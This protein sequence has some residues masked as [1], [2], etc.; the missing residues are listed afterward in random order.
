MLQLP[1]LWS[2]LWL[3]ALTL[4]AALSD[5]RTGLIPNWLT[6]PT[7][8]AAPLVHALLAGPGALAASLAAALLCALVPLALFGLHAIG[9]GDVKLFAAI[10]AIG[11]V[12]LGLQAQLLSYALCALG[13][14]CVLA[15]RGRLLATLGRSLLLLLPRARRR[16]PPEALTPVRLGAA[17]FAACALLLATEALT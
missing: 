8:C 1:S 10:G 12:E 14:C 16:P 6:L 15:Y 7:L 17:I 5:T 2:T 3:L 11:G 13:A 4:L 9:G